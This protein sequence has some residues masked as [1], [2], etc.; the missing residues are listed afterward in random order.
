MIIFGLGNPGRRYRFTRHNAGYLFVERLAKYYAKRFLRRKHYAIAKVRVEGVD[1]RLIKPKCWMNQC[2]DTVKEIIVEYNT[3]F[4]VVVD[5]INLPVGRI[6]LRGKGSDGGHRGLRSVI[7]EL[8]NESFP[9]LRIGVGRPR[10]DAADYV[11]RRFT[12]DER[13]I[14][15]EVMAEAIQGIRV[16]LREGLGKGQ[17]HINSINIESNPE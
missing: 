3:D 8:H 5:D 11:L 7:D 4:M 9:R 16:M 2:G 1:I 15:L 14:L 17:N 12:T 13:R 6:R 10:I